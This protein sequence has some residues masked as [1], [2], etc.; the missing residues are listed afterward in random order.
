METE[1]II[2]SSSVRLLDAIQQEIEALEIELFERS[3][4]T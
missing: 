2:F 1:Q 4:K 3:K